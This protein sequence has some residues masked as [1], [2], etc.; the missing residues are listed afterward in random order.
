[1][2]TLVLQKSGTPRNRELDLA[3]PG[4]AQAAGPGPE[5]Q[6]GVE[7]AQLDPE[8]TPLSQER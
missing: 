6:A 8:K 1:V 3:C 7:L 5:A 2:E 4:A